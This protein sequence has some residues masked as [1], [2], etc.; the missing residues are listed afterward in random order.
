MLKNILKNL[1]NN[2]NV[3][4]LNNIKEIEFLNT[5]KKFKI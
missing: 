2:I 3:Y 1:G 5:N 4:I